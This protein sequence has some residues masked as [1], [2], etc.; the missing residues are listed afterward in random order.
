MYPFLPSQ[1]RGRK[2]EQELRSLKNN[3]VQTAPVHGYEFIGDR[4]D[5]GGTFGYLQANIT[6]S[7]NHPELGSKLKHLLKD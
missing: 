4:Y 3:R 1:S 5:A 7:L 2:S 6:N